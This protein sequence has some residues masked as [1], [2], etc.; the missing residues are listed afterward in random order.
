MNDQI[1]HD[2]EVAKRAWGEGWKNEVKRRADLPL[3]VF[4][5]VREYGEEDGIHWVTLAAPHGNAI[6]GYARIPEGHPW[7]VEVP[8]TVTVHG[9]VTYEDESGWIGFDTLHGGDVWEGSDMPRFFPP[10]YEI[11]W[12]PEKASDEARSLARQIAIASVK[13]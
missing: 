6:N 8:D 1:D 9:G 13:E 11:H 2:A 4:S 5:C 7:R 3:V 12:T 10:E